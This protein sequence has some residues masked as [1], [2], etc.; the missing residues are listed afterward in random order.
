[1]SIAQRYTKVV[2]ACLLCDAGSCGGSYST[3]GPVSTGMGDRLRTGR[4]PRHA[5]SHPGQLTSY[6][7]RDGKSVLASVMM[8]C[9]WGVKIGV[10]L[11]SYLDKRVGGR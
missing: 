3:S 6:P 10:N 2:F 11:V 9:T 5:N 4:P 8:L 7:T 1:M